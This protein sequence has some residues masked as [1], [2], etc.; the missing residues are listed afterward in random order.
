M[1]KSKKCYL[2][3]LISVTAVKNIPVDSDIII[4]DGRFE[5]KYKVIGHNR[6]VD[7]REYTS[8]RCVVSGNQRY[9]L[10]DS[11]CRPA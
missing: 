7:S 11:L 2:E 1:R 8:L 5:A 3:L 4:L 6:V 9:I 10:P